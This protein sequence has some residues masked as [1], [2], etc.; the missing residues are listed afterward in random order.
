VGSVLIL[1]GFFVPILPGIFVAGYILQV[2]RQVI[3]GREPSLPAW[4]DWGKMALDGLQ[5]TVI[6]F[7]YFLPAMIVLFGGMGLYFFGTFTF[8]LMAANA[9]DPT[10]A[11][12]SMMALTFGSMVI[13]FL[14]M[15]LGMVLMLLGAVA[16]P[17]ATAHFVA[18][19]NLGAA[20]R[21]REWWRITRANKL[22]Y[23]VAWV[24][25]FGLYGILSFGVALLYYTIVLCCL[26][27]I[28]AAPIVFYVGLVATPLFGQSYR[29]GVAL[30]PVETTASTDDEPPPEEAASTE[31][32]AE[33][34]E[35]SE[36][37]S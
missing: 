16:T 3:A 33:L 26:M 2:M 27:P 6:G 9:S 19:D 37:E 8:P 34:P 21:L 20:F 12:G 31:G 22:G 1:A 13:M 17:M 4:D 30:L 10:Q 35:F 25:V 23:F 24:V 7:V 14:S 15:V 18:N 5:A 36:E 28:V 29:E 11:V 32:A